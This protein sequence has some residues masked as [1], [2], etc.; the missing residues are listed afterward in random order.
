MWPYIIISKKMYCYFSG[1][2]LS[3]QSLLKAEAQQRNQRMSNRESS[4]SLFPRPQ[5]SPLCTT[6]LKY[7]WTMRTVL[8]V[9]A[10][11]F[12]SGEQ[13]RERQSL[14]VTKEILQ[15]LSSSTREVL[16]QAIEQPV[17]QPPVL[18]R[19]ASI[20]ECGLFHCG[21][22]HQAKWWEESAGSPFSWRV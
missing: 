13:G 14:F 2:Y 20:G 9:R 15:H 19:C 5:S 8:L 12:L 11:L 4:S 21:A 16:V 17:Y 3:H 22:G 7:S 10:R 18:G 1:L 6:S